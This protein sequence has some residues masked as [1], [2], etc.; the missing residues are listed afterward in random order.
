MQDKTLGSDKE[1]EL[2]KESTVQ[3]DDDPQPDGE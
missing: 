3:T 1:L 2:V